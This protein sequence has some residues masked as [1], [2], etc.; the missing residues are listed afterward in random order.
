MARRGAQDPGADQQSP[1]A[2]A[3]AGATAAA[4]RRHVTRGRSCPRAERA[5]TRERNGG[6]G[7]LQ[8]RAPRSPPARRSHSCACTQKPG[9]AEKGGSGAR[10]TL[11]TVA[12][13]ERRVAR[14]RGSVELTG[15]SE[16]FPE[17]RRTRVGQPPGTRLPGKDTRCSPRLRAERLA[18]TADPVSCLIWW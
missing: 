16:R 11:R 1:S 10:A 15:R 3:R 6:P 8:P 18:A 5:R 4:R 7:R 13:S 17:A 12:V 14:R 9:N 2:V